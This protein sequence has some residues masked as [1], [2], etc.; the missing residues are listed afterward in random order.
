VLAA[1]GFWPH[2][3]PFDTRDL[4]TVLRVLNEAN[5]KR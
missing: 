4:V 1:T 5:K 2:D 3:I